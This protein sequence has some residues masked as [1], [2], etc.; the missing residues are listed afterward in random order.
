[1]QAITTHV[2]IVEG[3][4]PSSAILLAP[5]VPTF[6][7]SFTQGY[8]NVLAGEQF[9]LA[10]SNVLQA[11]YSGDY[12]IST[13][14]YS[15]EP[16][17]LVTRDNDTEWSDFVNWAFLALLTAENMTITQQTAQKTVSDP[18][19]II[20][21]TQLKFYQAVATVGNY[22]EMY[23]RHLQSIVPR[24]PINQQ[25][26]GV[27]PL[28]YSFPFG[29]NEAVGPGPTDGGTLR[30][31]LQRGVL[32]C[33][34]GTDPLFSEFNKTGQQWSGIDV[35]VCLAISA[36][37][38]NGTGSTQFISVDPLIRFAELANGNLDV[39]VRTTGVNYDR[40]VNETSTGKGFTF[41]PPNFYTGLRFGGIPQ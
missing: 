9:D 31:I 8:C 34:V 12:Y 22:E 27:T 16:T 23:D 32:R 7:S 14:L 40:D 2:S 5:T 13:K 21:L 30:L 20:Y 33:G 28:I 15:K 3:L 37:I 38:F 4:F 18:A 41:S 11:G 39:L 36:A 6:Y 19:P 35:N 24:A 25:N 1:V 17:A 26:H 10:L 29:N